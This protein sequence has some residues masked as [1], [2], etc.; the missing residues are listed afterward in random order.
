MRREYDFH[1]AKRGPVPPKDEETGSERSLRLNEAAPRSRG[2]RI[3]RASKHHT[4]WI[5][6]GS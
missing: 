4:R 2:S 5:L 3:R 6:A 1:G